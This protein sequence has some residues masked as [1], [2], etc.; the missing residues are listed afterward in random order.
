RVLDAAYL[1]PLDD[2]AVLAAARETG[3]IL[4]VEEHNPHGGLGSAVADVIAASGIGIRFAK[5][6]LPDDYAL[7]APPTHLYRHY[8][9]TGEG[10]AEALCALLRR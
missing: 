8:G 9:L 2:D 6:A 1:K 7:V 5:H 10:V 4:T 3:V